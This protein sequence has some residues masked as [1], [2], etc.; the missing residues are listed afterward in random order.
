MAPSSERPVASD[1]VM[2]MKSEDQLRLLSVHAHPDDES[3]KGAPTVARYVDE[4]VHAVLVCCTDGAQGDILNEEM[5]RPEVIGN[6]VKVREGELEQAVKVIGYN[7]L[8]WLGY[9]DSGM[10]DDDANTNPGCFAAAPL[11]EAVAR[12]AVMLRAERPHVVLSYAPARG[13]YEHPDHER[14][15]EI[16]QPAIALAADPDADLDGEPW[17]VQKLY[18]STWSRKRI[19]AYHAKFQEV[20]K[21]SP[22]KPEWFERPSHDHL[23]TTKIDVTGWYHIRNEAL[24]AHRT[25]IDPNEKFWFGLT[26]EESVAAYPWEDFE[27]V[28]SLV[29]VPEGIENDLMEGLR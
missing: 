16:T 7:T 9:A 20:G 25:Q 10:K 28:F 3:S 19:E 8:S 17:Q 6:L 13:G 14:V 2:A 29:P 5:N 4:G 22:Y 18:F 21:E 15:H 26:A 11:D 12:L 24:L 27:R 23:V 1:T